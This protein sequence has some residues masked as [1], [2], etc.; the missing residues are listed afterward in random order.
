[1]CL[2]RKSIL[3]AESTVVVT[4]RLFIS[5]V[6]C[7]HLLVPLADA[8]EKATSD[9]ITY[10][11]LAP[12]AYR[13]LLLD[14]ASA[15][16]LMIAVGERGHVL[17]SIDQ[18][19]NWQQISVPTRTML[20]AVF[21]YDEKHV[22]AVGHDATIIKTEDGG[23]Q[24]RRVFH[25]PQEESPLLDV[26]FNDAL[27]GY[28]IGAYG[29]FFATSDGGQTWERR[30]ISDD[31]FHLNHI[32]A[33]SR[34]RLYIA[35]E[36]GR[37]YRSDDAGQHWKSL[38]SPYTGSFFGVLPLSQDSVLL[39]GLRGH[40]YRSDDAGETWQAITSNTEAMLTHGL[41]LSDGRI[42]LA[43]LAGTLLV[44]EDRGRSFVLQQLEKRQGITALLPSDD[45][46][47]VLIGD[48]G[49]E[50][51]SLSTLPQTDKHKNKTKQ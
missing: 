29:L 6:L 40:L 2:S 18:G 47:V 13:S 22:W 7:L 10:S 21:V 25:A 8:Q 9:D 26:W 20:T 49:I 1:M 44:S 36:A 19:H 16:Q 14:G 37:I 45:H 51:F 39:Y 48:Q 38:T 12:L 24:W 33:G 31:D 4:A 27:N 30:H 3:V 15:G 43:G 50:R 41:V 11:V 32:A 34:D 28:V 23:T 35:A 17:R 5:S 42:I 46:H